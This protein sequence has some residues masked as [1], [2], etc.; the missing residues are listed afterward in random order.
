MSR[1]IAIVEDEAAL[2]ENYAAAFRRQGYRVE[3]HEDAPRARAA[4]RRQLPDLVILDIGLGE[5]F[6]G[7]FELCRELR[8]ASPRLPIIFLTARDGDLDVA[9]V[10]GTRAR[11][12]LGFLPRKTLKE[13]IRAVLEPVPPS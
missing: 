9:M 2:R 13:T 1:C 4:F 7:G 12:E 11:E 6:E 3:V 8:A 5:D 10:D